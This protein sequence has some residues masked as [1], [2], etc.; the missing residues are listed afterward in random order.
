VV[1]RQDPRYGVGDGVVTAAASGRG[2]PSFAARQ[3]L[4]E[5]LLAAGVDVSL[6]AIHTW[7][8]PEQGRAYLWARGP[9]DV[10]PPQFVWRGR[11]TA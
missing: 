7:T 9:S 8:R 5:A 3:A 10:P 4:R 1:G 2:L 6:V 11:V